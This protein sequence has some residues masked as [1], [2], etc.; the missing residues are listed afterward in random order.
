[1]HT[2]LLKHIFFFFTKCLPQIGHKC[3]WRVRV[4]IGKGGKDKNIQQFVLTV[5]DLTGMMEAYTKDKRKGHLL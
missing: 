3:G 4:E 2:S 5:A 1:M